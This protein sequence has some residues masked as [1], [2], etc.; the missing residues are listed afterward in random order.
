MS[1]EITLGG[2]VVLVAVLVLQEV[3]ARRA[4]QEHVARRQLTFA[5]LVAVV[6]RS[7]LR[8]P[9]LAGWLW[10]GWH[11]FARVSWR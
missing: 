2:Y 3:S 6:R 10:L 4:M 11:L 8:L 1:R 7:P 9:V 5:E